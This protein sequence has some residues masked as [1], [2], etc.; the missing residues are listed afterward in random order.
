[1]AKEKSRPAGKVQGEDNLIN[2][3]VSSISSRVRARVQF[4][5]GIFFEADVKSAVIGTPMNLPGLTFQPVEAAL[6]E[7]EQIFAVRSRWK[8]FRDRVGQRHLCYGFL[9]P[10]GAVV[11]YIWISGDATKA[12]SVPFEFPGFRILI[13]PGSAYIWDCFTAPP[14]RQQGLYRQGLLNGIAIC[15]NKEVEKAY[16]YCA[17]ANIPSRNGILSAG[18]KE[19]FRFRVFRIGSMCII[20]KSRE[21]VGVVK[22][23]QDYDPLASE[24]SDH[25]SP[26]LVW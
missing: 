25:D 6:F 9:N 8:T 20:K 14:Y 10:D 5:Y 12:V 2:R 23:G 17:A 15:S 19:K 13:R 7:K 16:I 1:M 4:R 26:H 22:I 18:F 24:R 3:I 11:S 21:G